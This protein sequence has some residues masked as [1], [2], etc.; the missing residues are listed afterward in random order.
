MAT[1]GW[2]APDAPVHINTHVCSTCL[3]PSVLVCLCGCMVL[4]LDQWAQVAQQVFADVENPT[5]DE[6]RALPQGKKTDAHRS[7]LHDDIS[8]VIIVFG[9]EQTMRERYQ[10]ARLS[11][12]NLL[13][14][15]LACCL[16]L[17]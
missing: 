6:L 7:C 3:G 15:L 14:G 16:R 5:A 10:R 8:V 4:I 11:A 1:A 9:S 2:P 13:N 17:C 12:L